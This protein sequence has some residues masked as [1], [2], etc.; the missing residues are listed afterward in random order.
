[1]LVV[2][3]KVKI[4]QVIFFLHFILIF[5]SQNYAGERKEGVLSHSRAQCA[6]GDEILVDGSYLS[7]LISAVLSTHLSLTIKAKNPI[8]FYFFYNEN[9]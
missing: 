9:R 5:V 8:Y 4:G 1:M 2:K 3:I 7:S 6:L